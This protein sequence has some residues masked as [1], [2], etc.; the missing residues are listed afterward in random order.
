MLAV[1]I[2]LSVLFVLPAMGEDGSGSEE[3]FFVLSEGEPTGDAQ[4]H[5][6]REM[7]DM[8]VNPFRI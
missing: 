6:P 5:F 7:I 1:A 3:P 2:L 8:I 4:M